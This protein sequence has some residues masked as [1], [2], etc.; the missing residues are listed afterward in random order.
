MI[1]IVTEAGSHSAYLG[2]AKPGSSVDVP[3]DM[4]AALLDRQWAEPVPEKPRRQRRNTNAVH[5]H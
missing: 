2:G 1:V 5:N 3:E 4:A